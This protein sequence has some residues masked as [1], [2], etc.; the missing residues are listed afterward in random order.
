MALPASL[1]IDL[2]RLVT[3]FKAMV[4]SLSRRLLEVERTAI[5]SAASIEVSDLHAPSGLYTTVTYRRSNNNM[6]LRSVLG[7][8]D[9]TRRVYTTRTEFYY[10]TAGA[11]ITRTVLYTLTYNA[12]RQPTAETITSIT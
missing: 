1:F 10:D 11:N 5:I 4:T 8:W 2:D 7:G 6:A 3:G 9:S 12:L